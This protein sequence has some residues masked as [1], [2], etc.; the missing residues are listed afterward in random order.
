MQTLKHIVMNINVDD[1]DVDPLFDIPSELNMCTKNIIE[2][3]PSEPWFRQMQIA[4]EEMTG[5]GLTNS[6]LQGVFCWSGFHTNFSRSDNKVEVSLQNLPE[7]QFQQPS[8]RNKKFCF[9]W[10]LA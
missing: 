9:I 1:I 7:T 8:L 2:L 10:F 5:V 6:Q 3:S 4:A